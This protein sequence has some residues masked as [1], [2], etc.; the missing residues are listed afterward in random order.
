MYNEIKF[1]FFQQETRKQWHRRTKWSVLFYP[2]NSSQHSI[3][4]I[5][6]SKG[7]IYVKTWQLFRRNK[8]EMANITHC[9]IYVKFTSDI[10]QVSLSFYY[11]ILK[12]SLTCRSVCTVYDVVQCAPQGSTYSTRSKTQMVRLQPYLNHFAQ[13]F[14]K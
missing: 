12:F 11:Y 5:R 14:F 9:P 13:L 3:I 1:S 2:H 8:E 7:S 4:K 10:L 6:N